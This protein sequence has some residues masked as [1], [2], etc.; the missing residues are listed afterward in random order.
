MAGPTTAP[1]STGFFNVEF[2][3][4]LK[5][6]EKWRKGLD[7]EALVAEMNDALEKA[8]PGIEFNFSQYIQDNVEEAASG[9]KGENSVKVSGNDLGTLAKLA[10]EVKNAIATVPGITDLSVF[11]SL[12]QPTIRIDI[13]RAKAAR[14]GLA[15]GD[16]N[17]T[18]QAAIGGQAAGDLYESGS[19]RHFPMVVRL[20]PR[21][22]ENLEAIKRIPIGVQGANGVTQVPLPE[23]A[24]I[25]LVSG[26]FY[27]YREQQE[28]Y[29]PVKFSVRGRDLGS[30]VIE[31]QQRVA[32]KVKLPGG[33]RVEWVGE[34]GNLKKALQRLA[35]AVPIAIS[36]ILLLLYV[37]FG[38]LRDTLLAAS[39]IPMALTGGILALF[40]AGMPF[41]IS[42]A[43]GF[44]ALFGIA[45]MNG[46]MVLSA[47][48]RIV[49]SGIERD[50]AL[51][52]TCEQ[53]MR[54]VLMTCVA[55]CVGLLPA[56]FSSA[57]GSQ[58]Q[59]PLAVVVVGGTLLAPCLFLTVLPAAIGLFSRRQARQ[60]ASQPAIAETP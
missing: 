42:A 40:I 54:P 5:P 2:F 59:R 55:A 16:I 6:M 37:S 58:V 11:A 20:A 28:R 31:A 18:V 49:E 24:T 25:G 10:E 52:R 22:R 56:A 12:G 17:A 21:Y 23:V 44:V 50:E 3:V 1:T 41:S 32:E 26:A 13:D 14:Y 43:I 51:R 29:V 27:I 15:P 46:I 7:K 34:F 38:T 4:P 45:A 19:D 57:I 47:Y 35:V 60:P 39:A 9:V 8:F 30:A 53:Q 36:L 48:N 33:Y